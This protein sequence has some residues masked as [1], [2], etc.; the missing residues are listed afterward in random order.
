[1]YQLVDVY[2][3]SQTL[4]VQKLL[5]GPMAVLRNNPSG[6]CCLF[7]MVPVEV[8][9]MSKN[10]S[11]DAILSMSLWTVQPTSIEIGNPQPVKFSHH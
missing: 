1:M 2:L 4:L 8:C 10:V 3:E 6:H 5:W 7:F 11:K 9:H